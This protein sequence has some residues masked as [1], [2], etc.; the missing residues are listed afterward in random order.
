MSNA[1]L[2][3]IP[4]A[5]TLARLVLSFVLFVLIGVASTDPK[6]LPSN[7]L[8][9]TFI[10]FVIT[11][12]TDVID[13]ALARR[14]KVTS[15]FGR[16]LDPFVDKILVLG[17]FAMFCGPNF[18]RATPVGLDS[19][20]G[21][22]PWLVVVLVARELLITV[23][24]QV[25]ESRGQAFGADWS[26]KLKTFIQLFAIGAVLVHANFIHSVGPQ[27]AYA[28][29]WIRDVSLWST[30]AITIISGLL[31]VRRVLQVVK[32]GTE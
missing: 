29:T 20:S 32:R 14:W 12:V 2:A 15:G 24:R 22:L 11:A 21:V 7:L 1:V 3:Q 27:L 16:V 18:T 6:D 26:G 5:I 9:V 4:N 17:C 8:T 10:L 30:A 31:Y 19:T 28:A 13:G 25:I 23:L